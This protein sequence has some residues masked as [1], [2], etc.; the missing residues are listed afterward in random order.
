MPNKF[1]NKKLGEDLMKCKNNFF[2]LASFW[3]ALTV[4]FSSVAHADESSLMIMMQNMQDQMKQMQATIGQQ[5]DEIRQLK[6]R[7]P[8]VQMAASTG[9]APVAAPMSDYEFNTML[10][11][12]TG[13]AQK[14][15]KN[16]SFKG[17]L[18]LR[19]E[20]FENSSGNPSET[21]DRNRF[22]YRLRYGFEKK[23]SGGNDHWIGKIMNAKNNLSGGCL[24][25]I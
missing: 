15:L 25:R 21:D 7:Q 16:L 22:R 3:I 10:D 13:G 24:H 12:A 4:A 6:S 19:Y 11:S 20:A 9:E 23:F 8:Q 1:N 18:R 17:D 14:W 5:S 2:R